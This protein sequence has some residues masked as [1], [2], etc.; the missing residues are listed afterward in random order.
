MQ[1]RGVGRTADGKMFY[2]VQAQ[3]GH[4]FVRILPCRQFF[5]AQDEQVQRHQEACVVFWSWERING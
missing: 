4:G 1:G 3:S 2:S 5:V